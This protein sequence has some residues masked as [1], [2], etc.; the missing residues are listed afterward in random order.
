MKEEGLPEDTVYLAMIESGFG[1][2]AY[3]RARASGPWQFIASTGKIFGLTQD[4]WVD[5]RRDPERSAHAAARFLKRLYD[6]TG[7]WRLAW[8]GYNAGVGRV[9]HAR[10][11]G[12]ADFWAMAAA[13]GKRVLRAE[14]K[15]YVPKLMAAAILAKHPEAFGFKAEEI[16]RQS[17]TDYAEVE[18]PSATLLS[19]V[20]KAAGVTERDIIDLN[21]ELRRSCT[22]PQ[23]V[24]PQDP[25]GRRPR[26]R[27]GLARGSL[28]GADHLRRP[29]DP[30]RRHAC[31]IS[32][33]STACRC[34]A[35]WR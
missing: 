34:R 24:L 25:V 26:V 29:R 33:P 9:R 27:G 4:F 23:E 1:N 14:T 11:N 32:P 17:W 31:A 22:P 10:R 35:S 15:G 3:S 18:I 28:Q 20:A 16:E 5:E 7:D 21:P 13:P 30:S 8:A 6:Q 2:F 12:Y 19:V